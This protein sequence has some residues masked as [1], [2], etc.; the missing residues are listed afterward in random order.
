MISGYLSRLVA[1]HL[2]APS[3]RQRVISR[4]ERTGPVDDW[5]GDDPTGVA[6]DPVPD[7]TVSAAASPDPGGPADVT[8]SSAL[9]LDR[10]AARRESQDRTAID[11]AARQPA[12]GAA[13]PDDTSPV[14]RVHH[15]SDAAPIDEPRPSHATDEVRQAARS[16][17]AVGPLRGAPA[18]TTAS[19]APSRRRPDPGVAARREPDVV[20]VHIGR[21]EVRAVLPVPDRARPAAPKPEAPRPLSL[22]RYLAGERRA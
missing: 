5:S 8:R 9:A 20:Q 7:R 17:S 3:I 22:D 6:H 12:L 10:L 18:W 11:Q 19:S 16:R 21:V 13:A 2:E 1:R 14:A 4:Y 15:R